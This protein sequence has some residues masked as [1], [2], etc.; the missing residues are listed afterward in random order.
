DYLPRTFGPTIQAKDDRLRPSDL[1]Y[2][3]TVNET[4][5][6][7][8]F[9]RMPGVIE[10]SVGGRTATVW[11]DRES[12]SAAAFDRGRHSFVAVAPGVREDKETK[13]RWNM[14][15]QCFAGPRKGEGLVPLHGLM[16][17]WYGWFAHH[18]GTSVWAE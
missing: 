18:P 4:A 14:D 3:V 1:V 15:G 8:P 11:F 6:A 2:G 9:D 16:A 5:R 17:E 13:S 10:E 12:R 7:Y